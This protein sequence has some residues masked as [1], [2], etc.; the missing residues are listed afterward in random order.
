MVLSRCRRRAICRA[1]N[2]T[3]VRRQKSAAYSRGLSQKRMLKMQLKLSRRTPAVWKDG[4]EMFHRLKERIGV[5]ADG[6]FLFATKLR[7]QQVQTALQTA[8]QTINRFQGK[9]QPRFF[10]RR[11]DRSVGQQPAEQLPQPHRSERVT[12]QNIGQENAK[13]APAAPTLAA[14]GTKN[15]LATGRLTVGFGRIVAVEKTVPV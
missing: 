4:L 6:W 7:S 2:T 15:A 11:L 13:G 14:V 10:S 1:K 8:P 3:A 5:R 12:R 9:R